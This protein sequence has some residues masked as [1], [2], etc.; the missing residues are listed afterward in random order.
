MDTKQR[1]VMPADRDP[2]SLPRDLGDG[3]TPSEELA[4]DADDERAIAGAWDRWRERMQGIE[5]GTRPLP[6]TR[7]WWINRLTGARRTLADMTAAQG[8]TDRTRTNQMHVF[9]RFYRWYNYFRLCPAYLR[10]EFDAFVGSA[11]AYL[12]PDLDRLMASPNGS[13][14]RAVWQDE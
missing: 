10:P 3:A 5:D 12:R 1:C 13:D 7:N 8:V 6:L 14:L 9:N 11:P 2:P 4:L